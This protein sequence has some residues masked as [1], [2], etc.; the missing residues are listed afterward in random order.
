MEATRVT[1]HPAL[2]WYPWWG[3]D[4][5]DVYFISFRQTGNPALW[6]TSK[7][8]STAHLIVPI[9]SFNSYYVGLM[10]AFVP[11]ANP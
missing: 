10:N 7:D 8:D 4:S 5:G 1:T 2:D 3:P 11:I 9:I 6:A